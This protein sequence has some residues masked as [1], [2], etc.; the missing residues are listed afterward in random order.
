MRLAHPGVWQRFKRWVWEWALIFLV[1]SLYRFDEQGKDLMP[2]QGP[3][4]LYYNHIHYADPFVL[5]SRLKRVRYAVP[6]AK[7]EL[8]SAPIIGKLIDWYGAIFVSRGDADLTAL[9]AGLAVLHAGQ[10]VML[11]PEG[12]R[13]KTGALMPA[14][15]GM[16]FLERRSGAVLQPVAVWGTPNFPASNKRGRR[17]LVHVRFGRPFRVDMAA[18]VDRKAGEEAVVEFA[19]QE[20]AALLPEDLRGVYAPAGTV[21]EWVQYV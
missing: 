11:A 19:M 15:R 20:L 17:A 18:D 2:S 9:R 21:P 10:V 16:G 3:L 14:Q 6:I 7:R 5:I 12:T 8:V 1:T 13:S 4:L